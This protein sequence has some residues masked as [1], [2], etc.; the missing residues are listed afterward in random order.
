MPE[1]FGFDEIVGERGAV[2]RAESPTTTRPRGVQGLRHDFLAAAALTF[3]QDVEWRQRRAPHLVAQGGDRRARAEKAPLA[4]RR[5]VLR[6]SAIEHRLH[7]R[8][9]GCGRRYQQ[10]VGDS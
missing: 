6:P 10:R 8:R 3:D 9:N 5:L 7:V 4:F 2:E 1:E